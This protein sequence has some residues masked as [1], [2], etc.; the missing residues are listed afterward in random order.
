MSTLEEVML[1]IRDR[2]GDL[3]PQ[4]VLDEARDPD[5]PLHHRFT[6]DDT[7]AAEKWRLAEAQ[8]LIRQVHV[9]ILDGP[10]QQ[11][12]RVRAFVAQSTLGPTRDTDEDES[13]TGSYVPV[14]EVIADDITRTA[15]F[16][17]LAADWQRLKRKAGACQEF[18]QYVMDDLRDE[19]G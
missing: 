8:R 16:R 3:K 15:W 4:M 14:R 17:S 6:W 19:A 11:P 7:D 10:K 9:T 12:I 1:A 13:L 18:A 5:H 2:H